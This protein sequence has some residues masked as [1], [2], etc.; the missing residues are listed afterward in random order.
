MPAGRPTARAPLRAASSVGI[1]LVFVGLAA[2][3]VA[4]AAVTDPST[5]VFHGCVRK[6]TG[7][8]RVIDPA[9]AGLSGHCVTAAGLLQESSITFD[10][11]G[12]SGA[13]GPAGVGGAPGAAGGQGPAGHCAGGAP[14]ALHH[15]QPG[16]PGQTTVADDGAFHPVST[17]ACPLGDLAFMTY[18]Q[19]APQ[20]G[21]PYGPG[22]VISSSGLGF[23]AVGRQFWQLTVV[24]EPNGG[25]AY[26]VFLSA[27]CYKPG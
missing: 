11:K 2:Y 22:F 27:T 24:N 6:A 13:A 7:V 26:F 9:K 12:P 8:L 17:A 19:V 15:V 5:G 14:G 20:A 21:G 10:Q 25:S 23:D 18:Y 16:W 3:G 1:S 4:A